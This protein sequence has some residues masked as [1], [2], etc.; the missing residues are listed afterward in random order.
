MKKVIVIVLVFTIILLSLLIYNA[1]K[2]QEIAR[3]IKIKEIKDSFNNFVITNKKT[4][5]Y[6]K[7]KNE[8]GDINASVKLRL[9]N[10]EIDGYYSLKD[11]DNHYIYYKDFDKTDSYYEYDDYYKKYIVFNQNVKTNGKTSFYDDNFNYLYTI[12]N[13]YELPIYIKED[14]Y[15]GVEYDNHLIYIKKSDNIEL[16]DADNTNLKNAKSIPVLLYHFF[17]NHNRFENMTTVIS[18][19]TD[20][21]EEQ[22]KYLK[23][24]DFMTLKLKDLESYI[25]GKV[26]IKENSVVI[27][28]DDG[29]STIYSL[30]YPIIEKYNINATV[31]AIT[32]NDPNVINKQ[33]D[34]I[35]IH[36]HTHNMHQTGKCS[37]GQGGYFKC[38]DYN[39]GIED[40]KKS[41]EVLNNTTYLA[42]PFGEYTDN[43][44]KML[45]DSGY[46]MALTTN[47]GN[48][49]VG[50]DPYLVPRIYIYN[51]YSI[52][53]FKR[54]VN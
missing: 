37:G 25:N 4:K 35:E 17:H 1:N 28:I 26:Q 22:M 6:D 21:F 18:M 53:T 44:I 10:N 24:N 48:A 45:K 33:T 47:Y 30:A 2:N 43:S 12:D 7:N 19:R 36:S 20:K 16:I 40:L 51:E 41:K 32:S 8:I 13:E 31:F 11:F 29:S 54:L 46:T 3:S 50:D 49:K 42:Y 5:L 34:Y 27:T 14:D 9:N 38:I 52:D 39:L 23:E 15:Y